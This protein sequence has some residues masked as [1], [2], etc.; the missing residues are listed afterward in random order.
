MI[1]EREII[2]ALTSMHT[3]LPF[4]RE[5][6]TGNMTLGPQK[7]ISKNGAVLASFSYTMTSLPEMFIF[8]GSKG[9]SE[10]GKSDESM[11]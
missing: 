9:S 11:T 6:M 4:I 3:F 2:Q 5:P 7:S 10:D 1:H 8:K